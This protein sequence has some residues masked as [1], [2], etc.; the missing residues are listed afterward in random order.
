MKLEIAHGNAELI[1]GMRKPKGSK[2]A[3]DAQREKKKGTQEPI[4]GKT[5]GHVKP[6]GERVNG[7]PKEAQQD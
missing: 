5:N 3:K 6:L 4:N 7:S 1:K 2:R